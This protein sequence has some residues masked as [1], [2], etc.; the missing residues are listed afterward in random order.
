[1]TSRLAQAFFHPSKRPYDPS[2]PFRS[3]C[4]VSKQRPARVAPMPFGSTGF[5]EPESTPT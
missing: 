3:H 4:S 1:M 5:I 2:S